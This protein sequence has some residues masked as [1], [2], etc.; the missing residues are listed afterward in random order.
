MHCILRAVVGAAAPGPDGLLGIFYSLF[1]MSQE[2]S[3]FEPCLVF[4][5]VPVLV[6]SNAD[7]QKEQIL[8]DNKK[9]CGIYR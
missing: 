4:A 1:S 3:I 5:I 7:L 6:Y 8:D 9:K 2:P